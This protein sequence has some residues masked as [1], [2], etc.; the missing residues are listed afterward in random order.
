MSRQPLFEHRS[1]DG[2]RPRRRLSAHLP[3]LSSPL[4]GQPA[5][6]RGQRDPEDPRHH[7]LAGH[8]PRSI[9]SNTFSLRSS[10]YALMRTLSP[11]IKEY[12]T[13]CESP[14][15]GRK[16]YP[17]GPSEQYD[18][19]AE[20]HRPRLAVPGAERHDEAARETNALHLSGHVS[21]DVTPER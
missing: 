11:R 20:R 15:P 16:E 14:T 4:Y 2:R 17:A 3:R 6:D 12:A 5:F 13:R 21:L 1:F 19:H 7:L 9:A 10:E 18:Q 8:P